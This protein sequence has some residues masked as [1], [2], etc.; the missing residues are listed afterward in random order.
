MQEKSFGIVPVFKSGEKHFFLLI[1]HS[2]GHWSFPKGHADEGETEIETAKRELEEETGIRDY[3]LVGNA[4]FSEQYAFQKEGELVNK[5]VKYFLA[6]VQNQDIRIQ[7]EEIS[8]FKWVEFEEAMKLIT[9]KEAREVLERAEEY[10][11]NN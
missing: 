7:P 1:K 2:N 11:G 4:S 3:E 9:H 10:L 5:T 6:I 8:D